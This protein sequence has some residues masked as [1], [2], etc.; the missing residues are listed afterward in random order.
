MRADST[1][2]TPPDRIRTIR[3]SSDQGRW[4]MAFCTPQPQLRPLVDFLVGYDESDTRFTRRHELPGIQAVL[5][6]NLGAPITIIDTAGHVL[7]IGSGQGFAGGLSE[8]YAVSESAGSQRGLQVMFTPPGA[9]RFFR[10]P[11][12]RLANRVFLLDEILGRE[13]MDLIA[14]L[15]E[16]PDWARRF[17]IMESVI[18]ARLA[19]PSS[20]AA[21]TAWALRQL[22]QSGGRLPIAALADEIGCSRKHL[23]AQFRDHVGLAPKTVAR[24]LRF[25]EVIRLIDGMTAPDLAELA[26][27][28]GYYDQAHFSRD[29]RALAGLPPGEYLRRRLPGQNGLPVG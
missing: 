27:A 19:E 28:A 4:E 11:M 16:A 1:G 12:H 21:S 5:I 7:R 2:M 25:Q 22:Q 3:T 23:A 10:L 17:D 24:I 15:Q 29:F 18:A 26:V 20:A 13:A 6:V 8:A 14:R 9:F